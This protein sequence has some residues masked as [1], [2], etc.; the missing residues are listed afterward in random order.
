MLNW[1]K[2]MWRSMFNPTVEVDAIFGEDV[3]YVVY[4]HHGE[5]RIAKAEFKGKHR[6]IC[7]CYECQK[8]T[9]GSLL[10]CMAANDIYNNCIKFGVCTPVLECKNFEPRDAG[11]VMA[12]LD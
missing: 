5:E 11:T 9:P 7:L 10:N 12:F 2:T 8:F 4:E 6:D 1:I 3:D